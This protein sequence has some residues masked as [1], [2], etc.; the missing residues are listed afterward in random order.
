MNHDINWPRNIH[1]EIAQS[2]MCITTYCITCSVSST[3]YVFSYHYCLV[4]VRTRSTSTVKK[5]FVKK[6]NRVFKEKQTI[7][8]IQ[9]YETRF[10]VQGNYKVSIGRHDP[11]IATYIKFAI[12][13]CFFSFKFLWTG[14]SDHEI[15]YDH[16]GGRTC[17]ANGW[18]SWNLMELCFNCVPSNFPDFLGPKTRRTKTLVFPNQKCPSPWG[19]EAEKST[20]TTSSD[21]TNLT[22]MR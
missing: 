6:V 19:L 4:P 9:K 1:R 22:Q 14:D 12:L 21:L 15:I 18:N 20:Q 17:M 7:K 13:S 5:H 3:F 2:I 11:I 16:T 8:Q 10:D